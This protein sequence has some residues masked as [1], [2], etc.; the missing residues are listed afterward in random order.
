LGFAGDRQND[1]A[2]EA[3]GILINIFDESPEDTLG[4]YDP[5]SE[6]GEFKEPFA[7]R[8]FVALKESRSAAAFYEAA[9]SYLARHDAPYR[10]HMDSFMALVGPDGQD[11]VRAFL[12][13]WAD[14]LTQEQIKSFPVGISFQ[15]RLLMRFYSEAQPTT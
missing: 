11:K 8:Y 1:V 9:I 3:Y 2:A 10:K 4:I 6:L 5:L 12:E 14:E 7:Q 13:Q 15:L